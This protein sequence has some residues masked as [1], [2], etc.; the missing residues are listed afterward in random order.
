[1]A[2]P[3]GYRN[4]LIGLVVLI[5]AGGMVAIFRPRPGSSIGHTVT[6]SDGTTL[7][8][9]E[10]TYGTEH[11]YQGGGW[12][13]RLIGLLPRKYAAKYASRRNVLRTDQP[14]VTLW[15]DRRGAAAT[16]SGLV[17]CDA[18]GFGVEGNYWMMKL[19]PPNSTMEGWA[20]EA[21]PR[22]GRTFTVRVYERGQRYGEAT[23]LGEFTV[24]N[25]RPDH[26][27]TWTAPP[28]P[29]TATNG[30]LSLTLFDLTAAVGR[31]SLKWKPAPNPTVSETR[32]GFR[33]RW[34]GQPTRQWDIVTTEAS[35]ATGNQIRA[36]WGSSSPEPDAE[37][38]ELHPHLWP[39][40]SA[41]KLRVGLSQRSNFA[42]DEV[43][44]IRDISLSPTNG[45]L[46]QTNL[47]GITLQFVGLERRSWLRGT[48][49]FNFRFTP[50]TSDHRLTLIRALSDRG[51]QAGGAGSYEGQREWA[52][53]LDVNTNATRL[54]ELTVAL[55]RTRYFKFFARPQIIATNT[56]GSP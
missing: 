51:G 8:L 6:Y 36:L 46:I 1:M 45:T 54:V 53:A 55:H 4:F 56:K 33:I 41:W 43:W 23:L 39:A 42:P 14:S 49:H 24:R 12:R 9:K 30:D 20:F 28:L 26:Y 29:I 3:G 27:P 15:L 13:E 34:N 22:R 31:G 47:Q 44:T 48:H 18:D 38:A 7:T 11:R 10:V 21:W 19:N 5:A 25:P 32:A 40:E 37:Y 50:A 35:D 52:F 2:K 17:L 16:T